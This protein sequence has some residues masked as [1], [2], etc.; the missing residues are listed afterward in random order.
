MEAEDRSMGHGGG[1]GGKGSWKRMRNKAR[2]FQGPD[3]GM[4]SKGVCSS[5]GAYGRFVS[6]GE[7]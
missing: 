2:S 3:L 7:L 1:G 6:S 5:Q 4:P